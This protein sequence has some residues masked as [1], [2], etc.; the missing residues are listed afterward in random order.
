MRRRAAPEMNAGIE[1][2]RITRIVSGETHLADISLALE[3]ASFNVLLGRTRAG[4][5][6]LLRVLAGLDRPTSGAVREGGEDV[7][8]AHVRRRS[9][10]MVY[11]QFVNYPS[12]RVYDNIASPLRVQGLPAREIDR[13][14][15]ETAARLRIDGLLDRLPEELSGGQQQR[16]AIARALVKDARLVLLDEPLA[17]LD[18]KLR[19]ELRH[20]LR[21]L[22]RGKD[23]IVVYATSEPTEALLLGG[24]LAVLDEGRL[25]QHGPA[26]DVY[27]RPATERVGVVISDPPM[28]LLDADVLPGGEA[29][30]AGAAVHL[31]GHLA[32][33]PPGPCRLGIRPSHVRLAPASAAD[34]RLEATVDVEEI[35]GSETLLHAAVGRAAVTALIERVTRHP[36]G[37]RVDLFLDPG[38]LFAFDR[39]GQLLAAPA[40]HQTSAPERHVPH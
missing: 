11:Q 22:F 6:S 32:D 35:G 8:R 18:Y 7:T 27:R 21:D 23:A 2:T 28:N 20:E 37:A 1:L 34:I 25:L 19:E 31:S 17:N 36:R 13:R 33:L 26:H 12:L 9:V 40:P 4:K 14:V 30:V 29:T 10:A 15:R 38:R 16:T 3:P 5:T 39:G 24:H